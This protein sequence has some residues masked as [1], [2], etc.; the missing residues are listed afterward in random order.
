MSKRALGTVPVKEVL[1]AMKAGV[2]GGMLPSGESIEDSLECV[3]HVNPR[4]YFWTRDNAYAILYPFPG[5]ENGLL[6]SDGELEPLPDF[7]HELLKH[8][9]L[10]R[11]PQ[12]AFTLSEKS[13]FWKPNQTP[14]IKSFISHLVV[15]GIIAC[16]NNNPNK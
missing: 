2:V 5:G 14:Q 7:A 12:N 10:L 6:F 9:L 1:R 13:E 15:R 4:T 11:G 3:S 8:V 16:S